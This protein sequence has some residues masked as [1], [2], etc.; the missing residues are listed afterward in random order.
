[1]PTAH[2]GTEGARTAKPD[3]PSPVADRAVIDAERVG[4]LSAG[5]LSFLQEAQAFGTPFFHLRTAELAGPP[6]RD[7]ARQDT[8]RG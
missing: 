8:G 4:D 5:V 6:N 3:F 1:M 2:S 7:D